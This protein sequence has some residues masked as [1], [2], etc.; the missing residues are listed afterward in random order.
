MAG[1]GDTADRAGMA[2]KPSPVG[3]AGMGDMAGTGDTAGTGAAGESAAPEGTAV[4]W[5]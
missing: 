3:M 4:A 2:D 1:T 5:G